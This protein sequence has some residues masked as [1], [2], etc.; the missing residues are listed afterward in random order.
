MGVFT[1]PDD[2][3][4]DSSVATSAATFDA[5]LLDDFAAA[6]T[7]GQDVSPQQWQ[8]P[9]FYVTVACLGPLLF[10]YALGFTSPS[11]TP[12]TVSAAH[13]AF[14]SYTIA[15]SDGQVSVTN[16][17]ASLFGSFV[18]IGA[19]LGALLAGVLCEKMG[20]RRAVQLASVPFAVGWCGAAAAAAAA[21]AVSTATPHSFYYFKF[22]PGTPS[23]PTRPS[24]CSSRRVSSRAS[25]WGWCPC[26]CRCT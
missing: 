21:A 15:D 24:P 9:T 25:A 11:Q 26:R 22:T 7:G 1:T 6:A 2:D 13:S 5:P 4:D 16:A 10:G 20:R 19:T 18:N 12:M 17:N 23:R 8:R 14:G 3:S